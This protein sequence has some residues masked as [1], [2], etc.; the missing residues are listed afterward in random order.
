MPQAHPRS[1][2]ENC[3]G[4]FLAESC[5]GSSPLTRGKRRDLRDSGATARLIPAHAGKTGL[6]GQDVRSVKAHPRS[7][8]ENSRR[9]RTL[10]RR[11]GS[12]PLTRGKRVAFGQEGGSARLIPAHA[13]KTPPHSVRTGARPAHPRSR[14]E[15]PSISPSAS[16]WTGSSPLTRG[17]RRID[18]L[19]I[20]KQG[21]IPAHAGKTTAQLASNGV[22]GAHPRSRG[23]NARDRVPCVGHEGLIPAHAGKTGPRKSRPQT[24]GAHPRSR[25]ENVAVAGMLW[26]FWGSSPLTRG[27]LFQVIEAT[28][29]RRLIPAHAGKTAHMGEHRR[30]F[31]AH[32]RSRGENTPPARHPAARTGSS[33]LTRGK[34]VRGRQRFLAAGL[35]PAHAGKT[36]FAVTDAPINWAHPR[37][38]GE[39]ACLARQ[40]T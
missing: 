28:P 10:S 36:P 31:T 1:R 25:G 40:F 34:P 35:I 26:S 2:G 9:T 8:G 39:N 30:D 24:R 3:D 18:A 37:S 14:G 13:G 12:S 23:E 6:Q 17:K 22:E 15:N 7:R 29:Q 33:P 21:L 32:P 19:M 20:D 11:S 5:G 16:F 38:R 27:K 4:A